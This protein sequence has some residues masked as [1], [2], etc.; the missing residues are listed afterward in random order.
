LPRVVGIGLLLPLCGSVMMDGPG[1]ESMG[2]YPENFAIN[3][4]RSH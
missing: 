1:G 3:S 2:F 4:R